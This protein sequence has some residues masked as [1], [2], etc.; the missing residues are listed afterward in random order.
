MAIWNSLSPKERATERSGLWTW[1][2]G[3]SKTGYG[4]LTLCYWSWLI[5]WHILILRFPQGSRIPLHF[6]KMKGRRHYRLN[7]IVRQAID[8]GDFIIKDPEHKYSWT[9]R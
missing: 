8:G 6:D 7:L 1:A 3:R 9:S 2:N 4:K 5:P